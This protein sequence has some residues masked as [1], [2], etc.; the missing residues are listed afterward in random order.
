[1]TTRPSKFAPAAQ[2][3]HASLPP[4]V[5]SIVCDGGGT[6][7]AHARL[8]HMLGCCTV[9]AQ[10]QK[11]T[12]L[13]QYRACAAL[14]TA[15]ATMLP[16]H[17]LL[18]HRKLAPACDQM[19]LQRSETQVLSEDQEMHLGPEPSCQK[20]LLTDIQ[21]GDTRISTIR[22]QL[23][24]GVPEVPYMHA[25]VCPCSRH[26]LATAVHRYCQHRPKM[27]LHTDRCGAEIRRPHG[28]TAVA[29]PQADGCIPWIRAH[30][31]QRPQL[32]LVLRYNLPMGCVL[33]AQNT[34]SQSS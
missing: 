34:C 16:S 31:S 8:L 14:L 5:H 9:A 24:V 32:W 20:P 22:V 4:E 33:I 26:V 27:T 10:A 6:A 17:Q 1:M 19:S 11:L 12:A 29:M 21:A 25:L 7:H 18:L 28:D 30:H 23:L 15:G 13:R 2:V 3:L